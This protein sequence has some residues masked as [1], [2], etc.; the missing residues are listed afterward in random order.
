M[1]LHAAN[2]AVDDAKQL[3]GKFGY[4]FLVILLLVK[5]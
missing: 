2:L 5:R 3:M 1:A 4:D